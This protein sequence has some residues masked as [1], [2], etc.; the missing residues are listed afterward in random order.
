ADCADTDVCTADTLQG[1]A[2]TCDAV[3]MNTPI[4]CGTNADGCCPMGCSFAQDNDCVAGIDPN[5]PVTTT[6]TC[7]TTGTGARLA[8]LVTLQDQAGGNVTGAT[9]VMSATSGSLSAVQSSGNEYW[10]VLT[11]PSASASQTTISITANGT[12]LNNAVISLA[13]PF[14]DLSGGA[15]GCPADGNLRVRVVD[16]AGTP[17]SGARV[18]VGA[19]E[20]AAVYTP[21][22]RGTANGA[23][24]A[25]TDGSGY[26][27]FRDFGTAL[28]GPQLVTAGATGRQYLTFAEMDASD[29]VMVLEQVYPTAP[30]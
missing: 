30:T 21:T 25:L 10:A 20:S 15:A 2:A 4:T 28:D 24:T 17:I 6:S 7:L 1:S 26:A 22:Y 8:I 11:A 9:V 3:C 27:T 12:P 19:T 18:M 23:N 16:P 13:A 29:I 5:S 14:P